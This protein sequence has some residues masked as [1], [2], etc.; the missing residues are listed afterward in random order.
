MQDSET[1]AWR[2]IPAKKGSLIINIGDM[3]AKWTKGRYIPQVHR[4]I[5]KGQNDRI[6]VPFF[7]NPSIDAKIGDLC[8]GEHLME[9]LS[10]YHQM[11][12]YEQ[13]GSASTAQLA[14]GLAEKSTKKKDDA[15]FTI[16]FKGVDSDGRSDNSNA[17]C[18]KSV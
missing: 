7:Y 11:A 5:H 14:A 13:A 3:M 4:V 15:P 12:G 16:T 9:K 6:S 17:V 1:K 18:V 8:Y 2:P 10:G